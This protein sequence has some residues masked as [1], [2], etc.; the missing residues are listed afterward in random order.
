MWVNQRSCQGDIS[1]QLVDYNI[2][3]NL[4]DVFD[5]Q[6]VRSVNAYKHN[7]SVTVAAYVRT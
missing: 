3:Q 2:S 7:Y 5:V 1:F 4:S 6:Y